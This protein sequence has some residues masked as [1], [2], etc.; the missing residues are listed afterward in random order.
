MY[1]LCSKHKQTRDKILNIN[2]HFID[3]VS[4]GLTS[5]KHI[6]TQGTTLM[7]QAHLPTREHRNATENSLKFEVTHCYKNTDGRTAHFADSLF[8]DKRNWVL[9]DNFPTSIYELTSILYLAAAP[10][11]LSAS[12]RS[13]HELPARRVTISVNFLP[14]GTE[15]SI[16]SSLPC[17]IF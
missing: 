7:K 4:T 16:P 13:Y 6:S 10:S 2:G 17:Y 12:C 1:L 5:K 15:M 14:M 11:K 3:K 8:T 9:G